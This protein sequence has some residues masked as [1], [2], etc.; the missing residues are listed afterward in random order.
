M[1]QV[2]YM[3][4][5]RCLS[6]DRVHDASIGVPQRHDGDPGEKVEIP[7]TLVVEQLGSPP[8]DEPDRCRR[9]CRHERGRRHLR[10]HF[11]TTI[12]PTPSLVRSSSKIAWV[13]R[14]SST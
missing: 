12:V 11:S 8:G 13:T 10:S 6:G 5:P 3:H 1:K 9:V 14:P 7:P 4:E 2:R